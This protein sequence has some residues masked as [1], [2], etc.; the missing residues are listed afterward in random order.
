M[1]CEI[2][3][4]IYAKL[5]INYQKLKLQQ[6]VKMYPSI[7]LKCVPA[8]NERFRKIIP[9]YLKQE[10]GEKD[11]ILRIVMQPNR[12]VILPCNSLNYNQKIS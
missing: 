5:F 4:N 12:R 8:N 6:V 9:I 1:S 2:L 11:F 10:L 3:T 7:L